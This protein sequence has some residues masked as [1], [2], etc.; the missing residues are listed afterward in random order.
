M[1]KLLRDAVGR[2]VDGPNSKHEH[3]SVGVV[4]KATELAEANMRA[5]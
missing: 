5:S 4:V 2:K 3:A 1:S